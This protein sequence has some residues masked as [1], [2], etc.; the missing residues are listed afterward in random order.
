[1]RLLSGPSLTHAVSAAGGLGFLGA[2]I[3]GR[4]F[5]GPKLVSLIKETAALFTDEWYYQRDLES[6]EVYPFGV[7]FLL[8]DVG[9]EEWQM[10]YD[11]L[12]SLP[13]LVAAIWLFPAADMKTLAK[14][15]DLR[16]ASDR[17]YGKTLNAQSWIQVG[18]VA[19]AD[20]V[21]TKCDPDV[22]VIQGADAG[23]HGLAASASIVS[24][25]PEVDDAMR[26]DRAEEDR[27]AL[28]AAGGI[29]D[30]RGVAAAS[31]L[32][33][34]GVVIGTRFLA[35][36]ECI[37]TKGYR[38]AVLA[39][40]DGGVNTVRTKIYDTLRGTPWPETFDGRAIKNQSWHDAQKTGDKVTDELK[41]KFENSMKLGDNA[42]GVKG[43][44][45]TYAGAAV[46][47]VKD[48]K[49]AGVIVKEIREETKKIVRNF[50]MS[51]IV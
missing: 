15:D 49:P 30:G 39:A 14:W 13:K 45:T 32:G 42:W 19:Q 28:I 44:A 10:V 43:R 3:P 22:L 25:L 40:K 9:E 5:D 2:G 27:I 26:K 38:N 18:T 1:M 8:I 29:T 33:A 41:A 11:A 17:G 35:T 50:A 36:P 4:D 24:L 51:G 20:E 21:A 48:V 6:L 46:G 12:R 7:G 37:I 31:M 16:Y 23:G 47:L 34:S